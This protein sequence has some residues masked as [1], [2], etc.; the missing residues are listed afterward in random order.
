MRTA[1]SDHSNSVALRDEVDSLLASDGK[2]S[3]V[4]QN[5]NHI[6]FF[7]AND[8]ARNY[9]GSLLSH[10][11]SNSVEQLDTGLI[12][13]LGIAGNNFEAALANWSREHRLVR[14]GSLDSDLALLL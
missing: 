6:C 3:I 13:E 11:L 4:L 7:H 12:L 2:G 1:P 10:E 8:N 14:I 9:L 5:L